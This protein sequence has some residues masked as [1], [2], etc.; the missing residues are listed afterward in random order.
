MAAGRY[1]AAA[2]AFASCLR[3]QQ[4]QQLLLPMQLS[5][6]SHINAC[7]SNVGTAGTYSACVGVLLCSLHYLLHAM[8]GTYSCLKDAPPRVFMHQIFAMHVFVYILG[9][10]HQ[11]CS[12]FTVV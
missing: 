6:H 4:Q 10:I 3:P 2:A 1:E 5:E 9:S 7:T 8:Q 11:R 12:T